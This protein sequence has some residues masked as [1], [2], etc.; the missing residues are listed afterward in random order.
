MVSVDTHGSWK[1]TEAF[2][3][4]MQQERMF[5]ALDHYGRVGVQALSSATPRDTGE[6]AGS[7]TY[8]VKHQ[9]GTHIL[10]FYN[11][12][13]EDN[14]NIAV[15]LQY[16]HGTGTGG[17]VEGLDYINP[18]TRPLFD[19]IVDDIWKAVRSA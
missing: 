17:W 7:W 4:F 8:D 6:T 16:G 14:V 10:T 9:R 5:A 13:K 18:V 15:I 2:L 12:H 11:S 19:T 1:K 3:Y